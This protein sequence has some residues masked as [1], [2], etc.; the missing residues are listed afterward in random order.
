MDLA[1]SSC[2]TR[3][4]L[5]ARPTAN[6]LVNCARTVAAILRNELF[7]LRVC[8]YI[9]AF[10]GRKADGVLQQGLPTSS[11]GGDLFRRNCHLT[12]VSVAQ[13]ITTR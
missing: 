11:L 1:A 6:V 5:Y 7:S 12:G 2:L 3:H 13:K 9:F 8:V 4:S 10:D